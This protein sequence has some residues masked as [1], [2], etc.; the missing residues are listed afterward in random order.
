MKRSL[1]NVCDSKG[2]EIEYVFVWVDFCSIPQVNPALQSLAINSLAAYA[3]IAQAF[4]VIAPEIAHCDLGTVCD[5]ASYHLRMWC[6]AEQFAHL[7]RNG[8]EN[9]WLASGGAVAQQVRGSGR[10][11]AD[12]LNSSALHVFGGECTCCRL[13]H[14]GMEKCDRESLLIPILGLYGELYACRNMGGSK[15]IWEKIVAEGHGVIFPKYFEFVKDDEKNTSGTRRLFG[16][17]V[18]EIRQLIDNDE[19]IRHRL[20]ASRGVHEVEGAED[21]ERDGVYI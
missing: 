21:S 18:E 8:P 12:F 17:L 14:K 11:E 19:G 4:V 9:M 1:A 13:K 15:L 7:L 3:S 20:L 6:R 2:W 10:I 5:E 16:D